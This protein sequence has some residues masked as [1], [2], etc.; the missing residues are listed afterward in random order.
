MKIKKNYRKSCGKR[1]M[2]QNEVIKLNQ[3]W[4]TMVSPVLENMT[5]TVSQLYAAQHI[6]KELIVGYTQ[7]GTRKSVR[8][9]EF[10]VKRIDEVFEGT[11]KEVAEIL[12]NM[13]TRGC[14]A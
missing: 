8:E 11:K 6:T 1:M 2:R 10:V 12:A 5:S 14:S 4:N 13:S 7:F 3:T 9:C